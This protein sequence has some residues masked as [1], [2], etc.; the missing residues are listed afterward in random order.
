M[1]FERALWGSEDIQAPTAQHIANE[2]AAVASAAHDFLD[3]GPVLC[4][5]KNSGIGL[6]ST[7]V[8]FI[9]KALGRGEQTR[10]DRCG[11]DRGTDLPHRLPNDV[12]K[13]ATGVLHE[14]PAVGNLGGSRERFGCGQ[15][16]AAA[17]VM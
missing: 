15:R 9:L 11:T 6:F 2:P 8:A 12:K 3:R 10:T 7:E 17:A 5:S 14:V 16:I 1:R 13:S 4:Q